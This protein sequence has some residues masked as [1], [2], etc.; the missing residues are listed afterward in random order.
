MVPLIEGA[1]LVDALIALQPHEV[2]VCARRAGQCRR[3]RLRQLGLADAGRPLDEQGLAE[4]I[5]E[6]DGRRDGVAREVAGLGEAV[7]DVVDGFEVRSHRA[8]VA[9]GSGRDR[10]KRRTV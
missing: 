6:E 5:S 8:I 10:R 9:D 2:G 1:G 7:A 3:H 4:G